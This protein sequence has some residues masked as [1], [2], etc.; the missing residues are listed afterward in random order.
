MILGGEWY[1][2]LSRSPRAPAAQGAGGTLTFPYACY[3]A[4]G[5][6]ALAG[7]RGRI[8]AVGCKSGNQP[9]G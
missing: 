1:L 8:D 2:L 7:R 9:G 3:P 5:G 6:D 4:Q